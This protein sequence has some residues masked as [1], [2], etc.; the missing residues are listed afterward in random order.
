MGVEVLRHIERP[1]EVVIVQLL[2][3]LVSMSLLL[4][5][6]GDAHIEAL[7]DLLLKDNIGEFTESWTTDRYLLGARQRLDAFLKFESRIVCGWRPIL[8]S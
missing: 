7:C 3:L 4:V 1:C 6:G 5:L 8:S 2:V